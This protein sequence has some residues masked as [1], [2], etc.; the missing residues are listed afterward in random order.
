MSP[1]S[2][3]SADVAVRSQGFDGGVNVRDAPNQ[4]APN[5][6][7]LLE[8]VIL[9]ER[10]GA[11][12][13]LGCQSQGTFDAGADRGISMYTFYR[14]TTAPQMLMQTS[15]GVLKYTNDA[16]ANPI[17]WTN[18]ATGLSST[19]RF[20]F[21]TFGGKAW[22]SNGV[23]AYASWDGTTY[24]TYASAPKGKYLRLW[25]DTMWV[26]GVPTLD[27]RVYSSNAGDPSTFGVA[28]WVDIAHGDGDTGTALAT[29]GLY[30][31]VFK[32]NRHFVIYDPATFANRLVDFEKGCESHFSVVEFEGDIYFL[33]RRGI[34]KYLGDTPAVIISYKLDPIFRD[35]V[36]NLNALSGAWATTEANRVL[37]ALPEVGSN[38]NT[39]Q[40][41]YYPRLG[42][43]SQLGSRGLGPFAFHRLPAVCFTRVRSGTYD[44]LF[45]AAGAANKVYWCFAPVG[46]DDGVMF[47]AIVETG[48]YDFGQPLAEKYLR[49]I[50]VVGRG[51]YN[52]F[53]R[54]DFATSLYGTYLIDFVT[55]SDV[56]GS[57][58]WGSDTWG[59][60][61]VIQ[62][63][64]IPID[65]YGKFLSLRFSDSESGTGTKLIGVGSKEKSLT[66]GEWAIYGFALEGTL[67]G[68]RY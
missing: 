61:A 38:I 24:T 59:P 53:T 55:G 30:L 20:S 9:D 65:L 35:D 28:S 26:L 63:K 27:D 58:N 64:A 68:E 10:G 49:L 13:R 66:G 12:K 1:R 32:R 6:C 31:I 21:E 18:I 41:E 33:S 23:D 22:F 37:W 57:G 67:L 15:A 3:T 7:R 46:T 51:R 11:E 2:A 45:G 50:R 29:D 60:A 44:R 48:A 17:V 25:K 19:A 16:T 62:S 36:L 42:P 47:T 14:G 40:L 54:R 43:V 52:F 34:C 5:E 56:W 4:L 39:M 8:N